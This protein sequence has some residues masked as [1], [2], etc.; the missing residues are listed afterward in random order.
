VLG[1]NVV[2]TGYVTLRISVN[3]GY[4][5]G[6]SWIHAGCEAIGR[7]EGQKCWQTQKTDLTCIGCWASSGYSVQGCAQ[8]EQKLRQCM[9]APVRL[10]LF[11]HNNHIS[12]L[13]SVIQTRRRTTSTTISRECTQRSKDPTN[14]IKETALSNRELYIICIPFRTP[15]C[16]R[17]Q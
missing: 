3:E 6:W 4:S 15:I 5:C 13:Y 11:G 10:M 16:S 9:D 14:G 8:L 2:S 7:I 12:D 17:Y 1:S